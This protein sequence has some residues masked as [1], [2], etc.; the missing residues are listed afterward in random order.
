MKMTCLI[1]FLLNYSFSILRLFHI[2]QLEVV[3]DSTDIKYYPRQFATEVIFMKKIT[4][5]ACN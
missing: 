3:T 4:L 2:E 1:D 5:N